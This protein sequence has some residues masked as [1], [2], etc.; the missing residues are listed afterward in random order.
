MLTFPS[1]PS[2]NQ[3]VV[4]GGKTWR[5]DGTRWQNVGVV[6]YQGSTGY[7]GSAGF[8]GSS[9]TTG[10]QGSV[11]YMGSM[12]YTGS[13]GYTGSRGLGYEPLQG[14]SDNILTDGSLVG[15][16][17]YTT[18]YSTG[19]YYNND[20]INLFD[21][22]ANSTFFYYGSI[23]NTQFISDNTWYVYIN[24]LDY[25]GIPVNSTSNTWSVQLTGRVGYTGSAGSNYLAN[26][27]D[28]V[29]GSPNDG[30]VLTYVALDDKYHI[31]PLNI[32]SQPMDGGSF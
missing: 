32:S 30:D 13:Q 24:I 22:T 19:A 21:T 31:L 20:F 28:V 27:L 4:T 17:V 18:V 3:E 16:S 29:V 11:G 6:G 7:Q 12:G 25:G 9:G 2:L 14:S 15:N 5:W 26:L 10:Y 23:S 8:Q 1:N